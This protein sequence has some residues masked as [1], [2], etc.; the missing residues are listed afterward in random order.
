MRAK[1]EL[2]NKY[3]KEAYPGAFDPRPVPNLSEHPVPIS[4][5]EERVRCEKCGC[6]GNLHRQIDGRCPAVTGWGS[7]KKWPSFRSA[8]KSFE[9][10]AKLDK[11]LARYWSSPNTF[12]PSR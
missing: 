7:P 5:H 6:G 1:K 11:T 10:D 8:G 3:G 12:V 2:W 9:A 4:S